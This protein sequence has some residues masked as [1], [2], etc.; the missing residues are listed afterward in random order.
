M[1]RKHIFC[2]VLILLSKFGIAQLPP[3]ELRFNLYNYNFFVNN[4][5]KGERVSGYTL[6]GFRFTPTL[7]YSLNKNIFIEAGVSLL[8][9]WGANK[10]PNFVYS[11]LP[12]WEASQY[13]NGVHAMPFFRAMWY[14]DKSVSFSFGNIDY[15]NCHLLSE[16]LYNIENTFSGDPE[17]GLQLNVNTKRFKGDLWLNWQTFI[18]NN[19]YHNETFCLGLA[20]QTKIISNQKFVL[21]LPLNAIVQHLG[22]ENNLTNVKVH[23]WANLSF[24]LKSDILFNNNFSLYFGGDYLKYKQLTG[25]I[26]P[27]KD[28]FAQF[29]YIGAKF[30]KVNLKLA[31]YD[32]EDFVSL[33]GSQHFC[34]F[35][36]NTPGL[37]FDRANQ[38][39]AKIDYDYHIAK[40]CNATFYCQ[41]WKQNKITGNVM[42]PDYSDINPKFPEKVIRDGF[43]SFSVGVV[44]SLEPSFLIKKFR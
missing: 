39:Y 30:K 4:E 29:Y 21:T 20:T 17:M 34:N 25:N 19:D 43:F 44:L 36:N 31:Y 27:F 33:L 24:G 2:L 15:R 7:S 37:I 5:Y 11:N 12:S 35:S 42:L 28:G 32:S 3:N 40:K 9:Y 23:S 1:K 10:Y 16:P 18:F 38:F 26:M 6:P 14:I 13:Q 41:L 8:H 22:G